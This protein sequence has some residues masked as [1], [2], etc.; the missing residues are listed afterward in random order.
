MVEQGEARCGGSSEWRQES[1]TVEN[2]S[3]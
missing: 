1:G 2:S 3:E